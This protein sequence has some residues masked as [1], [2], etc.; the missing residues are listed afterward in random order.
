MPPAESES[1]YHADT[2]FAL[3]RHARI[4][5]RRAGEFWER[6]YA[7]V[8]EFSQLPREG[9]TVYGIVAGLYPT[10]HPT[11]PE[12]QGRRERQESEDG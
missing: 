2:M 10:E 8:R 12:P 4:S 7:V 6:V 1:A 9:D 5:R 11:L 3:M